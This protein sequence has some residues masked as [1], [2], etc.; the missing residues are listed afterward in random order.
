[1][2]KKMHG[3]THLNKLLA[4]S[5]V[6]ERGVKRYA[7]D[8]FVKATVRSW[9][10]SGSTV[11]VVSIMSRFVLLAATKTGLGNHLDLK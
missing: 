6:I 5:R 11:K 7:M 10:T 9:T 4:E 1:M 8:V 3:R 2:Q